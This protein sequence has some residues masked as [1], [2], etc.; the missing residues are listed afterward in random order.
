[1]NEHKS[2]VVYCGVN[3]HFPDTVVT[4]SQNHEYKEWSH[5]SGVVNKAEVLNLPPESLIVIVCLWD[6]E[7]A[8]I[9]LDSHLIVVYHF[10]SKR[11]V[12]SFETHRQEDVIHLEALSTRFTDYLLVVTRTSCVLYLLK[13]YSLERIAAYTL[14]AIKS[15]KFQ[16]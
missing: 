14:N 5:S 12:Y 13:E 11:V 1:M 8:H 15:E 16:T 3:P 2:L 6:K 7:L 10:T 9:A 4:I